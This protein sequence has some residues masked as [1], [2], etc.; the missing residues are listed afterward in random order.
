MW[1]FAEGDWVSSRL[2]NSYLEFDRVPRGIKTD[3][4]TNSLVCISNADN[5]TVKQKLNNINHLKNVNL[6]KDPYEDVWDIDKNKVIYTGEGQKGDQQY[7]DGN[8]KLG[9]IGKAYFFIMENGEYLYCGE[10][11][12]VEAP[13]QARQRDINDNNRSVYQFKMK[14]IN[15]ELPAR[16]KITM[17]KLKEY[18][19][20]YTKLKLHTHRDPARINEL[21]KKYTE[22]EDYLKTFL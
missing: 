5:I 6:R 22:A 18:H 10:F 8:E 12:L 4:K 15:G 20:L 3:K 14:Y 16:F 19:E 13:Y 2:L 17:T 1:P 11:K 7:K 21:I 9:K